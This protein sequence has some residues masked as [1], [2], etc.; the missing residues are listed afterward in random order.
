MNLTDIAQQVTSCLDDTDINKLLSSG[1]VTSLSFSRSNLW[2]HARV[3]TLS[4][5]RTG[6]NSATNWKQVY[7]IIKSRQV[8][9]WN[10]H[11]N[12]TACK[13]LERIGHKPSDRDMVLCCE[14]GTV[15]IMY[16]LLAN[17]QS[18]DPRL[19]TYN[20]S[21]PDALP[22]WVS[23]H[24][25]VLAV[26]NSQP[27]IVSLLLQDNRVCPIEIEVYEMSILRSACR[28]RCELQE[29]LATSRSYKR[30]ERQVAV[31]KLLLADQRIA[32]TARE[33]YH[34]Y[35]WEILQV[36]LADS[37]VDPT[38][39][40][41]NKPL[42]QAISY[43]NEAMVRVYLTDERVARLVDAETVSLA[44]NYSTQ[45]VFDLVVKQARLNSRR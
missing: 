31:V 34:C 5:L 15:S 33:L 6:Y 23:R 37:Q 39:G 44:K 9:I 12:V 36:L 41:T 11:D 21:Q 7:Y 4:G 26:W 25:L 40:N 19:L 20:A 22:T 1:L 18:I 8:G 42:R 38:D 28:T 3:E 27:V 2:W 32:P 16:H 17:S 14:T 13:I 24:A 30:I 10:E 43:Q 35:H 29:H 45:A